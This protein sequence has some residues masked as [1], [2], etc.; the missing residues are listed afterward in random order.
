M[1]KHDTVDETGATPTEHPL[2]AT[3]V[4]LEKGMLQE[5]ARRVQDATA[6]TMRRKQHIRLDP[7]RSLMD[8]WLHK[9]AIQVQEWV[10]QHTRSRSNIKPI[11]HQFLRDCDPFVS[12]L[13]ALRCVLDGVATKQGA[14]ITTLARRIGSEVEH[15]QKVRLW[16]KQA[17]GL[18]HD[19]QKRLKLQGA[20]ARHTRRVNIHEFNRLMSEGK[21]G[22][23]WQDWTPTEHV[24][25]GA[26][27]LNC[28]MIGTGWFT[29]E[30]METGDSKKDPPFCLV[31]KP[32]MDKWIHDRLAKIEECSPAL[33]PTVIPPKRWSSMMDGGYWTPYVHHRDLI[34]FKAIQVDQRFNARQE[35]NAL[36]MPRVYQALHFL[37]ETPWRINQRI[38]KVVHEA[39]QNHCTWGG[40]PNYRMA[41]S[42]PL[43]I[44]VGMLSPSKRKAWRESE[45]GRKWRREVSEA[46][47]KDIENVVHRKRAERIL[48]V[49]EGYKDF[50]CF[51]FPHYLD[52]RGRMYPIPQFLQPQ[53]DD[54]AKGLLEFAEGK[55]V[56]GAAA[57]KWLAIN[58]AS[59]W[60]NDKISFEDR[61]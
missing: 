24:S 56:R 54:L 8:G 28:L 27:L 3:Q 44:E 60:G 23:G 31:F 12:A 52:W 19:R 50:G 21:F 41:D 40:L 38:Y 14:E 53:G 7:Y 46:M 34:S 35:Y 55:L 61:V 1:S 42:P 18:Y 45:A 26:A 16:E 32:G 5:G 30:P 22:T 59:A 33:T 17:P 25:V 11:A 4:A 57:E 47:A 6:V 51:Y 9:V 49:V 37:Q 10:E 39:L 15:E 20:D 36:A 43:P 48:G 13:I 29:H 2:W 58:V